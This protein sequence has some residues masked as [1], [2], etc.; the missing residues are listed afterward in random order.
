MYLSLY[1]KLPFIAFNV[2]YLNS[3]FDSSFLEMAG[4]MSITAQ[5]A[6]ALPPR[7]PKL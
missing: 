6:A 5:K 3:D 2:G 4:A 7:A 1:R